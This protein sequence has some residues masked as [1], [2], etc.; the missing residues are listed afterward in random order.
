MKDK[1]PPLNR[2]SDDLVLITLAPVAVVLIVLLPR[3]YTWA[4][5]FF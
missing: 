3:L 4:K 2:Q 5:S 1:K